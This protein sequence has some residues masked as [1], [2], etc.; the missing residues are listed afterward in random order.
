M[1]M[2]SEEAQAPSACRI[3][4][5]RNGQLVWRLKANWRLYCPGPVEGSKDHKQA[6]ER[7]ADAQSFIKASGL[8]HERMEKIEVGATG[9]CA[10]CTRNV[11]SEPD[12]PCPRCKPTAPPWLKL[13]CELCSGKGVLTGAQSLN[14]VVHMIETALREGRSTT[15]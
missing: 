10:S 9:L 3:C 15:R 7:E 8:Y 12:Y 13:P 14:D 1:K 4:G 2:N 5:A 11:K 6:R